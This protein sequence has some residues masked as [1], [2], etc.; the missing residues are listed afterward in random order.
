MVLCEKR[1]HPETYLARKVK[2][3]QRRQNVSSLYYMARYIHLMKVSRQ[4][5]ARYISWLDSLIH[6]QKAS[7]SSPLL[8]TK[9][10]G[11]LR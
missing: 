7:G 9:H 8:A 3:S 5:M 10:V 2:L 11:I 6:T 4:S 1:L